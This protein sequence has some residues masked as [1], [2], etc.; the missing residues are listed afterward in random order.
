MAEFYDLKERELLSSSRK[1]EIVKP[2]Q[3]A[4]FLLREDLKNSYPTIGRKLGGKDHT[5]V[6]YGCDKVTKGI[7][8]DESL[9][10]EIKLIRQR[11]RGE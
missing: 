2:R 6:I 5:T 7:E 4:M 8:K 1:K 3:I 9:A 10:E 11:V